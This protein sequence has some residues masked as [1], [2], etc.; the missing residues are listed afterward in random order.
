MLKI[1][2]KIIPIYLL[3]FLISAFS[4]SIISAHHSEAAFDMNRVVS[5][6]ATIKE[7][8]W[9]NPHVYIIIESQNNNISEEWQIETGAT[10]IMM[11]SGWT[12]DILSPG[13]NIFIRVHPE[14]SGNRN[15]A[16]LVAV[17]KIDGTVLSQNPTS[18]TGE[19]LSGD[20]YGTWRASQDSIDIFMNG[21]N[22]INLNDIAQ[23]AKNDYD[24]TLQTPGA[25]CIP[26]TVPRS[27]VASNLFLTNISQND[28]SIVIS[29]EYFD[30]KRDV[31]ISS[32]I[33]IDN[34]P[35]LHGSSTGRWEGVALIVETMNYSDNRV[36]NGNGVPSGINKNTIEKYYLIDNGSKL[37]MDF[38]LEDTGFLVDPF[39]SFLEFDYVPADEFYAYD[40]DIDTSSQFMTY[41]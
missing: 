14:R 32:S 35:S 21:L 33:P 16:M 2:M 40:C 7:L 36:G 15:Y 22:R 6:N 19:N 8:R 9:R 41:E 12:S 18:V 10:P 38:I 29:S 31:L 5:F 25:R 30:V 24:W 20:L 13:E 1:I 39:V 17:Q 4:F 37:R 3:T 27:Y 23:N 28:H 11:R 26:Y 34:P